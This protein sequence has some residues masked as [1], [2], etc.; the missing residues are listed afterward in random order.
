MILAVSLLTAY[1]A[2]ALGYWLRTLYAVVR[3][4][5]GVPLL[6]DA[7]PPAPHPW[8]RLSVI[9]PARNE[10]DRIEPAARTLL[11]QD[12]GD[13]ELIFVDDRS[14]DAT[15]AIIDRIAAGDARVRAIHVA[16][17]PEGWLGKV[18]ALACGLRLAGGKYVLFTDA[19]VHFRPGALRQAVALAE[20][21]DLGHLAALPELSPA[22]LLLDAAIILFLRQLLV[23]TRPWAVSDP[24]SQAFIGI[25]AFN[26]VRRG[27]FA[28]SGGFADLRLETA[29]DMGVGLV[30]K[31]AGARC[32]VVSARGYIAL[33]WYR[34]MREAAR[35]A[36]R[37]WATVLQFSL[38]RTLAVAL[39]VLV[40]ETAPLAALVPLAIPGLW[41]AGCAGAVVFLVF[42]ASALAMRRWGEGG[43]WR[44][45]LA[46]PLAA[47]L[48]AGVILR[49]GFLGWRRGGVMWRGTLYP[50]RLLRA[51]ARV[52]FR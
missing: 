6:A 8:P 34:T 36:E 47:P 39:A 32:A 52:K 21:A 12:Y 13:L 17:L 41:P 40:L 23:A 1:L 33:H 30:M 46:T 15:G 42:L 25:G 37:G 20:A 3:V 38:L 9:I 26:L 10:A 16:D 48:V 19:D 11:G 18:H 44:R 51:G 45:A 28:G 43:L 2:A 49:A 35:G 22:S 27:A 5:R 14:T 29:D 31:R 4:R 7:R 50:T 24:Q